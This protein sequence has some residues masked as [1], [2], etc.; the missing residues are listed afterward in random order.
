[1]NAN[2]VFGFLGGVG[3]SAFS[4]MFANFFAKKREKNKIME[5]KQ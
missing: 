2:F 5:E 3:V 1:M 4:V